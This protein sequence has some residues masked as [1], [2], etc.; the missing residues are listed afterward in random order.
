MTSDASILTPRLELR[1]ATAAELDAMIEGDRAELEAV[2]GVAVPDPLAP[3]PESGDVLEW[4]HD[5][6]ADDPTIRP[7]FFRWMIQRIEGRLIGSIGF[8]GHP[9][10]MGGLLMGYSVY[11]ADESRGYTSEAATGLVAWAFAQPGIVR[12]QA[13]IRPDHPA[14]QRVAAKAGLVHVGEQE[15]DE[16]GLVQLWEIVRPSGHDSSE[17][18]AR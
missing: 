5:K 6:I 11:P 17:T 7:W 15:D 3:P 12:V 10:V 9:D 8:T 16:E 1:P 13:T 18:T 4:F 14:S 2:L